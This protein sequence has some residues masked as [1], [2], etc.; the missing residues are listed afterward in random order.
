MRPFFNGRYRL[1]ASHADHLARVPEDQRGPLWPGGEDWAVPFRTPLR[2]PVTGLYTLRDRGTGGWTI[3]GRAE[4]PR[5]EG[6]VVEAMHVAGG[7]NGIVMGG[8]P[9][10][11]LEGEQVGLSGG[12]RGSPGAGNST[13][14]HVHAHAILHGRRVAFT[15]ALDWATE[16]TDDDMPTAEEIWS[17]PVHRGGK[18]V[19]AIQELADAKTIG[20]RNEAKLNALAKVAGI[21]PAQLD[22]IA[23]AVVD[24]IA[25]RLRD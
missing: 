2:A 4:D 7:A 5:L 22:R 14:A 20:L 17:F 25:E 21:D 12:L 8:D 24:E 19:S 16:R 13:G 23:E 11:L 9:V 10:R 3:S 18:K 6:L 15:T 1:T